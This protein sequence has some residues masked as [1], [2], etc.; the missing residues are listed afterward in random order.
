MPD[1]VSFTPGDLKWGGPAAGFVPDTSVPTGTYGAPFASRTINGTFTVTPV[2]TP[3]DG[4]LETKGIIGLLKSATKTLYVEQLY[5]HKYWGTAANGCN[6]T[7]C[8]DLFLAEVIAAARRGV[9]V[10]VVLDSAFLDTSDPKDNTYT[11]QY[12]NQIAANEGL[13][14]EARLI[15]LGVTK[16]TKVHNKGIIVDGTKTLVSSINWSENSPSDNRE[17]GLIIENADAAD[18]YTDIFYYDWYNGTPVKWV[19]L[20]EVMYDPVGTETDEEWVELHNPTGA[21]INVGGWQLVDN[22]ASSS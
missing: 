20:S 3:E 22:A 19:T 14:M 10:R 18:F 21:A 11:V 5:A 17:M 7:T 16:L 9:K 8:P 1:S 4:L 15:D 12:L 13:D 2:V 6:E